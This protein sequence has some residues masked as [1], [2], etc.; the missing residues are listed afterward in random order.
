ME[1]ILSIDGNIDQDLLDKYKFIKEGK[2][3]IKIIE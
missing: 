1:Y 2:K 3:Y